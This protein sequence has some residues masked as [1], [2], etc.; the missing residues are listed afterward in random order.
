MKNKMETTKRTTISENFRNELSGYSDAKCLELL[1]SISTVLY[2]IPDNEFAL[3]DIRPLLD[4]NHLLIGSLLKEKKA[5][6]DHNPKPLN[7][8]L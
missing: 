2:I 3:S 5:G 6:G 7:E 8:N 4:L 1:K